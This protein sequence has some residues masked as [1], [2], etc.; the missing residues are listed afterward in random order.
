[1]YEREK[2]KS[3]FT[4][5]IPIALVILAIFLLYK[6]GRRNAIAGLDEP[7]Q[8][9]ETGLI[10]RTIGDW[11]LFFHY[12]Y[13]YDIEALVIHTKNYS[14]KDI[15]GQLAPRDLALAWGSV[16]ALNKAIDFHWSQSNRWYYWST[17]SYSEIEPI[18]LPGM[19]PAT[20]V[21]VQSAN[22]HVIAADSS[23]KKVI[24]KI[25]KGDHVHLK[26][27]LVNI[28]GLSSDGNIFNW[29]SSTSRT[30]T[31]NGACEVFYVTEARIL[32]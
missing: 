25:R 6:S 27:Y 8:T 9:P 15:G 13:A 31:G 28:L 2:E 21:S 12:D 7:L 4:F 1:M 5:I 32:N 19:D 30:D 26:G 20:S 29:N 10:E 23:V 11:K 16:A 14:E 17:N 22:T 18:C 24:S 3:I